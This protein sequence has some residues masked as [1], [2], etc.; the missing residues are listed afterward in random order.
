MIDRRNLLALIA[1]AA[2][3]PRMGAAAVEDPHPFGFEA[4]Q[5]LARNLRAAPYAPARSPADEVLDRIEYVEHGEIRHDPRKAF[6]LGSR[7]PVTAFPLGRLFRR[8]VRLYALVDGTASELPYDASLFE[9][10]AGGPGVDLPPDAGFAGFRLHDRSAGSWGDWA[11]FLGASYFRS[12]GDERQY[13]IS[14][15]GIAINTADPKPPHVEEFPDFT[16]FYVSPSRDGVVQVLA[17]LEGPSLTG[18]FRFLLRRSPRVTFTVSSRLYLR[19]DVRRLGIAPG[20]SMYNYSETLRYR[21]PDWRP[22]VHDSDGLLMFNGAGE[23]LW[24]PLNNPPRLMVSAFADVG[25]KGFGLMQRDRSYASYRDQ[26][27]YQRR[28]HLWVEPDGDWGRGTVQLVEIPTET[29]YH[30]NIVAFWVPETPARAG[31]DLSFDY[32]LRF[33]SAEPGNGGLA[34]C[35]ATRLS[36]MA[37]TPADERPPG[38]PDVHRD[39]V[40]EFSGAG[41][42]GLDPSACVP[43]LTASRGATSRLVVEPEPDGS[44]NWRVFFRMHALGP[45]PIELRLSLAHA[46]RPVAETWLY[47]YHP[48]QFA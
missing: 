14:A 4:L 21:G 34:R 48:E 15:R 44:G 40:I 41:I 13:G 6:L 23:R 36:R 31:D 27:A 30:D 43:T 17:L 16:R 29:E 38:S 42:R 24:R 1:A 32:V 33:S 19:A 2:L 47:Q 11:A 26:V 20:T 25:P 39:F 22:E 18:A 35:V 45:E 37:S 28:P 10:P 8:P 3:Q 7:Y 9:H 46:G 12:D 5:D